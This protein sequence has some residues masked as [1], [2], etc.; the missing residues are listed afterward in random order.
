MSRSVSHV[1][2][3]P[4]EILSLLQPQNACTYVDATFGAGG[5]SKLI[6]NSC[7]SCR[8][9]GLDR[10]E[11][12]Q[13]FASS[14]EREYGDR[15]AFHNVKFSQ[16]SNV[17]TFPVHGILFDIGVSSM[18]IDN[19]QRGFSF[20]RDGP[21]SMAMGHNSISAYDV[22]NKFP[23]D[24]LC[25]ILLK[26]GEEPAAYRIAKEICIQRKISPIT[27]TIQL[28]EIVKSVVKKSGKIH[29]ATLTFQAIRVFV[30]DELGE[31]ETGLRDALNLLEVGGKAIVITFQ[32]LEDKIVKNIFKE[33]THRVHTN[34]FKKQI[35]TEKI[36]EN[37]TKNAL[38]ASYKEKR[39]NSRARSAKIRAVM[40]TQ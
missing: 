38:K 24:E 37:I 3:M 9:I 6:L 23:E 36:F 18:Q 16:I 35:T 31:L 29:P 22:V 5:H 28:A 39:S 13:P 17:I 8:V 26:Y 25:D 32:G 4:T 30:N 19:A 34:K 40:R 10:D 1:S 12:V 14:L 15:F 21:L 20:M 2:V 27:T 33:H 7:N 11:L